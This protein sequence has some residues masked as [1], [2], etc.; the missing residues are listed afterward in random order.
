MSALGWAYVAVWGAIQLDG[1]DADYYDA[2]NRFAFTVF[3]LLLSLF[4]PSIAGGTHLVARSLG[5]SIWRSFVLGQLGAGLI[6]IPVFLLL[7]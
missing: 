6:A 4:C 2:G 7:V 1:L 3:W 5:K